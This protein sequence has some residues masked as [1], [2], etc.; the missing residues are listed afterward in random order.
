MPFHRRTVFLLLASLTASYANYDCNIG[1]SMDPEEMGPQVCGE[2]GI[3]YQNE[4]ISFCQEIAVR[5]M[6]PCPGQPASI[7]SS[8]KID[9]SAVVTLESMKRF[10]KENFKF[11]AK[12]D[13]SKF[14]A[15]DDSLYDNLPVEEADTG[16]SPEDDNS[17]EFVRMTSDGYEYKY[18]ANYDSPSHYGSTQ[19]NPKG[20]EAGEH[21]RR[22]LKV[23]G[24]DTRSQ[25]TNTQSFPF[26]AIAEIDYG[27]GEGGCTSTLISRNAALTAG[28]CVFNR[29]TNE[30]HPISRI[31]PGR[32][33]SESSTIEPYGTWDVDYATTF[34]QYK[35][36][37]SRGYDIAVL[38]LK[39]RIVANNED[40]C[41]YLYPGDAV[42]Y[43]GIARP[44]IGDS[45][46]NGAR[47]TGYPA[48]RSNGEMWT[49][50]TCSGGWNTGG[51]Y[52]GYHFCDTYGG[53][54]GSSVLTTDNVAL[55]VH[56]LG[57]S[58]RNGANLM[59]GSHYNAV[60]EWSDDE[61]LPGSCLGES[62]TRSPTSD[63]DG[64]SPTSS[65]TSDEEGESPT[66]SPTPTDNLNC[67][68]LFCS[69]GGGKA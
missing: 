49:S 67:N 13:P 29:R 68:T 4:C 27:K 15:P 20:S 48:D 3:T 65:P 51:D 56:T 53:N 57:F 21:L 46:L 9:A 28:H 22:S 38:T 1:C 40:Q 6:G 33:R 7:A 63:E 25:V 64:E 35:T 50:G 8:E 37:G 23:I 14:T 39:P 54:S 24:T 69:L 34:S 60:Y 32:Y 19:A 42:G 45:R 55:G 26:R 44:S 17:I 16:D 41:D 66:R 61:S 62:P 43:V 31:A 12:R 11:V 47:I 52:F 5:K 36:S 2:D 18:I 59:H 30:Y 10:E 58:D